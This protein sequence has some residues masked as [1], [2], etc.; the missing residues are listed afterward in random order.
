MRIPCRNTKLTVRLRNS[1]ED[2]NTLAWVIQAGER[3][4]IR[5]VTNNRAQTSSPS[6]IQPHSTE[7]QN[8][9][10]AARSENSR[11]RKMLAMLAKTR[12]VRVCSLHQDPL[13]VNARGR[14]PG[15]RTRSENLGSTKT[16]PGTFWR[17]R[18]LMADPE[19][20]S[21]RQ[22]IAVRLALEVLNQ[23]YCRTDFLHWRSPRV[24]W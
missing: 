16:R 10:S 6:R 22:K 12:C 9:E 23:D 11:L 4:G 19:H 13:Y 3:K 15:W 24:Q 5:I 1:G 14:P 7:I 8:T 2:E 17:S 21:N 20:P 18:F